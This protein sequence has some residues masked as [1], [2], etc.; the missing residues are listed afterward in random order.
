MWSGLPAANSGPV[1]GP[2]KKEGKY[3]RETSPLISSFL[4]E[5]KLDTDDED[6]V[7]FVRDM[8]HE[9]RRVQVPDSACCGRCV[10]KG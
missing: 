8:R 1:E 6:S 4:D 7:S 3:A 9:V 2:N 10:G 5:S